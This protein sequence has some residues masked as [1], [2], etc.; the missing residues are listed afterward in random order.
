MPEFTKHQA[1]S[2]DLLPVREDAF[3]PEFR[4]DTLGRYFMQLP[5][6][7]K[8][9]VSNEPGSKIISQG[10]EDEAG[11]PATNP[12]SLKTG[13]LDV[14]T[15]IRVG[16]SIELNGGT[17]CIT[18][19]DY[20][21]TTAP[22]ISLCAG[23]LKGWSGPDEVFAFFLQTD[24]I[25][26]QG[27][28]F[29]GD[30]GSNEYILW[31]DSAGKLY[32][33]G[34]LVIEGDIIGGS[35][36]GGN[37]YYLH[38][39]TGNI[40]ITGTLS[41][42]NVNITGGTVNSVLLSNLD[43][44][45][46]P[47][48]QGWSTNIVFT[49]LDWDTI[50]WTAGTIYLMDGT[51]FS[52]LAGS[53]DMNT[54]AVHYIYYNSSSTLYTTTVAYNAVGSHRL[55]LCVARRSLIG[56]SQP[57]VKASFQAFGTS[58]QNVF[59]TADNM[60]ADTIT[61]NLI[62]ANAIYARNIVVNEID[63]SKISSLNFIG[64]NAVFNT[65]TI[66]G[67]TMGDYCLTNDKPAGGSAVMRIQMCVGYTDGLGFH[68]GHIQAAY[69]ENGIWI[70]P[71]GPI[72]LI[73]MTS[74]S[75]TDS[76]PEGGTRALPRI[77]IYKSILGLSKKKMMLCED[78]LYF[79]KD[80][81]TSISGRFYGGN[82][83]DLEIYDLY[84]NDRASHFN[85]VRIW[86]K[87]IRISHDAVSGSIG[88]NLQ[89]QTGS[90]YLRMFV[91]TS[92]RGYAG[93]IDL[94]TSDLLSIRD[95]GGPPGNK[96]I[97]FWG[98]TGY[99]N[100]YG[101]IDALAP[102]G[103]LNKPD[104]SVPSGASNGWMFY[105][106]TYNEIWGYIGGAWKA[107]STAASTLPSGNQYQMLV[108]NGGTS[109][110]PTSSVGWGSPSGDYYIHKDSGTGDTY[111]EMPSG[112]DYAFKVSSTFRFIIYATGLVWTDGALECYD[113]LNFTRGGQVSTNGSRITSN[114]EFAALGS[115][116]CRGGASFD[117]GDVYAGTNTGSLIA[118]STGYVVCRSRYFLP[119]TGAFNAAKY[120]LREA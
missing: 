13:S 48:I 74:G 38:Y 65:G 104:G 88:L 36:P 50:E 110:S 120:Y 35:Y 70:H 82:S 72:D 112:Q 85:Y 18:V 54:D 113:Q 81:G 4:R 2:D 49:A 99:G 97:D 1:F 45:S 116:F 57:T 12:G 117:Q 58:G 43:I 21:S 91:D 60:A 83:L 66:G 101:V 16:T 55:L 63:A 15:I 26:G 27:D 73:Q 102:I 64:K 33:K 103:L 61:A 19:G 106:T 59:I 10:S 23:G 75:P 98:R 89:D 41:A 8:W 20:G 76:P 25:F 119:V 92:T 115:I 109:W 28:V 107:L 9:M 30:Y 118:G 52:V 67:W 100:N 84:I 39:A 37:Y 7:G 86:D 94:P 11:K 80:D 5:G 90:K 32:V 34:D 71:G 51:T 17:G 47:A 40:D 62:A 29:I 114:K 87:G 77:D 105:N 95:K 42:S 14:D 93:T 69:S 3:K 111:F 78:G 24:G 108:C 46:E 53:L 6:Y 96:I 68:P 56:I 22:S 31:D 79:F 44:G